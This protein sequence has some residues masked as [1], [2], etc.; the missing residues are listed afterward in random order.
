MGVID[1]H[2]LRLPSYGQLHRLCQPELEQRF[3]GNREL[4]PFLG[5]G[6]SRARAGTGECTNP[7]SLSSSCYPADQRT[8]PAPPT[9]FFVV[10]QPSPF[11][12]ISYVLVISG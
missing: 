10:F 7:S 9:T 2:R 8:Q 1:N 6:D 5:S 4:L 3:A 12:W 11:P